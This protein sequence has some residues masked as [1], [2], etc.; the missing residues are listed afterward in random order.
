MGGKAV[1]GSFASYVTEPGRGRSG[2]EG[3]G[4]AHRPSEA[5]LREMGG[6]TRVT[7]PEH[8]SSGRVA[9]ARQQGAG[10]PRGHR[11]CGMSRASVTDTHLG[12]VTASTVR[13]ARPAARRRAEPTPVGFDCPG[14]LAPHPPSHH[15]RPTPGR[16]T[17][18]RRS[19][20]P[21]DTPPPPTATAQR[22]R[23]VPA[24][25]SSV[26]RDTW[27]TADR[28]LSPRRAL[29]LPWCRRPSVDNVPMTPGS[30]PGRRS[31]SPHRSTTPTDGRA[32]SR[33]PG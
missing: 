28:R 30:F 33:D 11:P 13:P 12:T 26:S 32:R 15:H 19:E 14:Y 10:P 25:D 3:S 1:S 27:S 2:R 20:P 21:Q 22:P 17:D 16:R 4:A 9:A 7:A 5:L 6:R 31:V 29:V 24:V 23:A 18:G 8:R